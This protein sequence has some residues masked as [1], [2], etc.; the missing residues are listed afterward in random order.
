MNIGILGTGAVGT[1]LATALTAAGHTVVLG[2][3]TPGEGSVSHSDAARDADVL[4]TALPGQAVIPTLTE[5]GA[6][7]LTDTV[8]LDVSNGFTEQ[9]TLAYPN[10]S[11]GRQVQEAFPAARVVKS[12]S[13]MNVAVMTDPAGT[14]PGST[15]F[16]SGDDQDA[17]DT[18][19][20]LLGDLGWEPEQVFDLGG[21]QTAIGPEHYALLFVGTLTALQNPAFNIAVIH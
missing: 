18:V 14:A 10:D 5:I 2:S 13:T 19:R 1:A 7:V 16:L 17:K 12:L 6:D 3:R 20:T 21:I 15:V 8:V 9:F 11:V 4:I